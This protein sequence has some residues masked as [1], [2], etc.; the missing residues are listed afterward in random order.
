MADEP[1]IGDISTKKIMYKDGDEITLSPSG[2]VYRMIGGI[3]R[4]IR[5]ANGETVEPTP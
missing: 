2:N 3:W 1:G 5:L 4:L